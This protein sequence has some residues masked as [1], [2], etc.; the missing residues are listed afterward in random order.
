M[1]LITAHTPEWLPVV[2]DLFREYAEWLGVSLC[3]QGFEAELAELP[4][5][6]A[7]PRG[8]L[9][10]ARMG[11]IIVGCGAL[12]PLDRHTCEMKRLYVRPAA[13]G[14]GVGRALAEA[15]IGEGRAAGYKRMRLDTLRTAPL[16]AANALYDRLGF[17]EIPAYYPNPLPDVRYLEL[18]LEASSAGGN[19]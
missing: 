7:P 8:Q 10:L 16:A 2:R 12:R 13:R 17:S 3:F 15:L 6:Y 1:E 9:L 14:R 4:G 19:H 5:A 18:D 11:R